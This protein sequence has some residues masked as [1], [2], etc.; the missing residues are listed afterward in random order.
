MKEDVM[1]GACDRHGRKV[2]YIELFG[3][4]TRRKETAWKT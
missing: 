2:T 1:D 4:D 3:G